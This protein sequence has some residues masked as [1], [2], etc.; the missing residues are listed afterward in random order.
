[1]NIAF[2]DIGE[3]GWSLL[4]SA[5]IRWIKRNS[6]DSVAVITYPD[7]RCLYENMANIVLDVPEDF[8]RIFNVHKQDCFGLYGVPSYK[9]SSFFASY[10]PKGYAIPGNPQFSCRSLFT[11]NLIFEPY[12]YRSEVNGER[13]ILVFPRCRLDEVC[14]IARNLP[15]AFYATLIERL[16]EEFQG[17]TIRTVGTKIGAYSLE[18]GKPNYVNWVGKTNSVQ[19]M[20]DRCQVAVTAIGAQS[21]PPKIT[22]LQGVPTFMIG[23][24]GKRHIVTDNWMGTKAGFYPVG[25][26]S[27]NNINSADCIAK[28]VDFVRSCI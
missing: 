28:I 10:V 4:L 2:V 26:N 18:S 27:Y 7:R 19:D 23:H 25:R 24:E 3:L 5:R 20:I 11:E 14:H 8:Y 12:R 6:D 1:M 22:L 15:K 9:I 16:C 21:A 13:E 17:L